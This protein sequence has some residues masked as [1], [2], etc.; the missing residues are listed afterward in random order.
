MMPLHI[1]QYMVSHKDQA[2][3]A[4][5]L[6]FCWLQMLFSFTQFFPVPLPCAPLQAFAQHPSPFHNITV[7]DFFHNPNHVHKCIAS[8]VITMGGEMGLSVSFCQC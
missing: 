4:C 8:V 2:V 7:R 1:L 6:M 3:K 5:I